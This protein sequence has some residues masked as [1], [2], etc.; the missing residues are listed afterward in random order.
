MD[1]LSV[2]S[3]GVLQQSSLEESIREIS[4]W[5]EMARPMYPHL[6]HWLPWEDHELGAKVKVKLLSHV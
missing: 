2:S 3:R 5:A 1:K 6:T 4:H